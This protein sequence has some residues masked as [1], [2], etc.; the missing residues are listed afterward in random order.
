MRC[1]AGQGQQ[2]PVGCCGRVV[3]SLD[4]GDGSMLVMSRLGISTFFFFFLPWEII[5]VYLCFLSVTENVSYH[6]TG[7]AN[8]FK[9]QKW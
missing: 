4:V 7:V 6:Q 8:L 5:Q 9:K 2:A 1:L 3:V